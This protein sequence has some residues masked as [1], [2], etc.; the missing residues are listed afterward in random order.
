[1][2]MI[3]KV[4]IETLRNQLGVEKKEFSDML[5]LKFE[6][7]LFFEKEDSYDMFP[8]L[9][10]LKLREIMLQEETKNFVAYKERF[11]K[12]QKG[13]FT[14]NKIL[15]HL[16]K[17]SCL[18]DEDKKKT[19][20][21]ITCEFHP[22]TV[23]NHACPGCTFN[24]G[25]L[26]KDKRFT[27]DMKLLPGVIRDLKELD[28]RGIDLS[29]GGEPLCHPEIATIIEKFSK[30]FD[31]GLVTNGGMFK[32]ETMDAVLANCTWCR[33]SVD[34]ASQKV[35]NDMHGNNSNVNFEEI[36]K[37]ITELGRKKLESKSKTTLGVSFLLTPSNFLD[38][39]PAIN[40]FKNIPG[41]DYFQ[42]K[43][44]VLSPGTRLDLNMI[45]WD[46]RLFDLLATIG[47]YSTDTFNVFTLSYKFSDMILEEPTGV[48]FKKCYGHPFYP[49]IAADGS[50]LICC[51][52]LNNY[53]NGDMTGHYGKIDKDTSFKDIWSN[54]TRWETGEAIQTRSCP[55]NCKLSETNK[56]LMNFSLEKIQHRNFIN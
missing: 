29:G 41:I 39:L 54:A 51:H 5:L 18:L 37:I 22:S 20:G 32:P 35:Y 21:P 11:A 10:L 15:A 28:V 53:F 44:I 47:S 33:V 45:F 2:T 9:S 13:I 26:T 6:D 19:V 36:V 24:T 23:C 8:A 27:F 56:S 16:D 55:I 34:A 17:L 52:M 46:K 31:V 40:I 43:P 42:T 12:E 25:N 38:V 7:Y 4:L 3:D 48:P 49:T 30:E 50:V 14:S 1:M